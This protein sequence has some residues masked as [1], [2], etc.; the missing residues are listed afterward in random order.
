MGTPNSST[1]PMNSPA[2][3]FSLI[4]N[5]L[6]LCHSAAVPP[7]PSQAPGSLCLP[8]SHPPWPRGEETLLL[9]GSSFGSRLVSPLEWSTAPFGPRDHSISYLGW[10]AL[11]L[12]SFV[13]AAH[14]YPSLQMMTPPMRERWGLCAPPSSHRGKH[15]VGTGRKNS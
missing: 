4:G 2:H 1:W 3:P 7:A 15:K 11:F 13:H 9:G 10:P 6:H 5:H 12:L 14:Q 8:A